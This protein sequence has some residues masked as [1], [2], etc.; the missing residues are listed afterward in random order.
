MSR[1]TRLDDLELLSGRQDKSKQIEK[2][3][4]AINKLRAQIKVIQEDK[5]L[6]TIEKQ[7]KIARRQELIENYK[8]DIYITTEYLRCRAAKEK[9]I[10]DQYAKLK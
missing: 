4:D 3:K 6:T 10:S 7:R 9:E 5:N 1:I 2:W 8:Q